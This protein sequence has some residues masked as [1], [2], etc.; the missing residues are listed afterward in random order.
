MGTIVAFFSSS[1][2]VTAALIVL[3]FILLRKTGKLIRNIILVSILIVSI[4]I[5]LGL[6][7]ILDLKCLLWISTLSLVF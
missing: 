7:T 2:V 4:C 5:C 1:F 3:A 6:F